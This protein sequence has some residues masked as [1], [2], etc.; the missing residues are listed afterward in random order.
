MELDLTF[1]L[2]ELISLDP[3]SILV[4]E[5]RDKAAKRISNR[6]GAPET[7]FSDFDVIPG[8]DF[9]EKY[10]VLMRNRS[11]LPIA[12][13]DYY[14]GLRQ[15]IEQSVP[16][17]NATM[18]GRPLTT[19]QYALGFSIASDLIRQKSYWPTLTQVYQQYTENPGAFVGR[20]IQVFDED[21]APKAIHN[22]PSP[23]YDDTGFYPRPRLEQELR[24]K[25]LG[26][27]P[28]ITVLGEGGAGKSALALQTLYGL[29]DNNDHDFDAVIWISAKSHRLTT[30]EVT[31]IENAI[32]DSLGVFKAAADLLEPGDKSPIQRLRDLLSENKVL[33]CIDNLETIID[34]SVRDFASDV[35]G[36]S[37]L[38][39]T[40]RVPLGSDLSV[41]VDD[42]NENEALAYLYRL[43]DAYSIDSLRGLGKDT[44]LKHIRRLN[45]KPLL[46][47]WFAMGVASGADPAVITRNPEL[48]LNFCLENVVE[49]LSQHAQYIG[50]VL[51]LL[52]K[53][54]SMGVLNFVSELSPQ[55][56]EAAIIQLLRFALVVQSDLTQ[57]E[58]TY[59]LRP[60]AK[61]YLTRVVGATTGDTSG[62]YARYR[63]VEGIYQS[64]R[65]SI[66]RDQYKF[67]TF[68]VRSPAEALAARSLRHA[69]AS[70]KR[71][72]FVDAQVVIDDLKITT[73]DYFE[74]YRIEAAIAMREG[75]VA[76][77]RRA[78]EV[79]LD[80]ADDQSQI[81]YWY[82]VFLTS[83]AS[84]YEEAEKQFD[85][86][87]DLDPG[88]KLIIRAA[89]RNKFFMYNFD[90][91]E[92]ALV[93]LMRGTFEDIRE[94]T[95]ANDLWVQ[96]HTRRAEKYLEQELISEA[97][98]EMRKL[99]AVIGKLE[100]YKVDGT[101]LS[102]LR[103]CRGVITGL[104]QRGH[105]DE[106]HRLKHF[107]D[108]IAGVEAKVSSDGVWIYGTLKSDGRQPTYGFLKSTE[109]VDTFVHKRDLTEAVWAELISGAPVRYQ[110]TSKDGQSR[111]VDVTAI[112]K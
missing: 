52:P 87:M 71:D 83:K 97:A 16:I 1:K 48:A 27:H 75:D 46:L 31:R 28:V 74:I 70:L 49:K 77:A 99:F 57:Y 90:D 17:R 40:S 14:S 63:T 94:E 15:T 58:K 26:R 56:T 9:A 92:K 34:S 108:W 67:Q 25:I 91:A 44:L 3:R 73:P 76:K 5:E 20:S 45:C 109:G 2:R 61:A 33:L 68:L 95:I 59:Q 79:A 18:H 105:L 69:F 32:T 43:C 50:R 19:V 65:V 24:A 12:N 51:A 85:R 86:A 64:D 66:G 60:F 21:L 80:L 96:L 47:K 78:Y 106:M 36:E 104:F 29:I 62:I 4:K 7:E 37:K 54:A 110:L 102:H 98:S 22:L 72:S 88:N 81:H 107:D 93:E 55:E 42:F 53:P 111:A 23:D 100:A 13:G 6:T 101:L 10:Q 41:I 35:P 84:D 82:G 89:V 38:V 30:N 39:F 112:D 11:R 103:K 8:L